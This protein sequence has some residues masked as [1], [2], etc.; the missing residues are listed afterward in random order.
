MTAEIWWLTDINRKFFERKDIWWCLSHEI[1]SMLGETEA[2]HQVI[3]NDWHYYSNFSGSQNADFALFKLIKC[4][5]HDTKDTA[6]LLIVHIF[7][8][9]TSHPSTNSTQSTMVNALKKNFS[10]L[11]V[12]KYGKSTQPSTWQGH[13]VNECKLGFAAERVQALGALSSL[14][15]WM[16]LVVEKCQETQFLNN[17]E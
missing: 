5:N 12:G 15:S 16:T 10:P 11:S 14:R 9:W 1:P 2:K 17:E 7:Q 3:V 13:Q 4:T 6:C 8:H